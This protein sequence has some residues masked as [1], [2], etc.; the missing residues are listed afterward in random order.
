MAGSG[1]GDDA[2]GDPGWRHGRQ[3]DHD[4]ERGGGHGQP[5]PRPRA[6]PRDRGPRH[7]RAVRS[8]ILRLTVVVIMLCL[9][10]CYLRNIFVLIADVNV[11]SV[12]CHH[13]L[14]RFSSVYFHTMS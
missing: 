6:R 12:P 14:L 5:R 3:D 8:A 9:C 1:D 10:Q 11:F 4:P 13:R 7:T 2:G